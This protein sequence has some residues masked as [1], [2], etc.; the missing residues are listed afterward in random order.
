MTARSFIL[1]LLLAT[2]VGTAGPYLYL[3]VDGANSS[4]YF[5]S[6]IALFLLFLLVLVANVGLGALHRSWVLE[7]GELL[8]IF[9]LMSL[10][11]ATHIM[12]HYWVP[13][14]GSPFYYA[15]S[16]NNWQELI[17]P[18]IASWAVPHDVNAIRTFFE[19][20]PRGQEGVPWEVW[21][22][23]VM[24]W[25]PMLVALHVAT[26][27]LMVMVRRRWMDQERLIYPIMQAPL[28]MIEDDRHRSLLKPFFRNGAMWI[29]FSVPMIIGLL[30]GMRAY[31][32]FLPE[33]N[34]TIPF[35]LFQSLFSPATLAFFFLVQREVV[36]G[37]WVFTLLNNLQDF[38][39]HEVGWGIEAEPAVSVWSYGLPSLV[40]QSV[41]AM[42]V[43][44]LGGL[45]VGREHLANVWRKAFC[46]APDVE[47]GEEIISY[48]SCVWGLLI[49]TAVMAV[50]LWQLGL[51]PLGV[52]VFLFFALIIF[53]TL[54][55]VIAE[56]GVA[57][58][59]TPMVPADAAVSAVGG[60]AY[61]GPGLVGLALT[62]VLGNDLLNFVMPHV[63][64]GLRL[65]PRIPGNRR[66]L[67][68]AMLLAILLAMAGGL[69]MLFYLCYRFG[70]INMRP[71]HF[72]WLPTYIGDY[73]ASQVGDPSGPYWPGWFH[74][75]IGATVMLLL[76]MARR[77][78]N[79]WP[80]H[81]VGFPISSTL[82]W[83]AFNAFLA[84]AIKGPVLR[85]GGVKLYMQ[86]RPFFLGMIMGQ[87]A[88]YGV[89]WVIDGLTGMIGNS[90]IV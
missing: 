81:P 56:G 78:W 39:Y 38:V 67:F 29:G 37:L 51:P 32:P 22:E 76:M 16:E 34:M 50:W 14:V 59:Y 17:N 63:A 57:V 61:G 41:G 23:P 64:N 25:L 19:G 3:Y 12:V 77:Y 52:V 90:T 80:L 60:V 73:T 10:A 15:R 27:C 5:T 65:T 85:Y 36:F 62:R 6:Q 21:V 79:W 33:M 72:V 83:I 9:L 86:V 42:I 30:K 55:R 4:S 48:R 54:T 8:V 75:G 11:N 13:M 84:W 45:W 18:H 53:V 89:L 31:F 35:P 66:L 7:P 82:N 43:L 47:D 69:W 68:W 46:P 40:H 87:F 26:L 20:V 2:F 71:T 74:T 44:V 88:M 58:I 70:A 24:G 49:S 1:G 28:A